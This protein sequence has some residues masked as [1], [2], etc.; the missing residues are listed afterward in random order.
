LFAD[1]LHELLG[2]RDGRD[3]GIGHVPGCEYEDD[4]SLTDQLVD[5][6]SPVELVVA[7]K[8]E[9]GVC[10]AHA[11]DATSSLLRD[12]GNRVTHHDLRPT[13]GEEAKVAMDDVSPTVALLLN[14]HDFGTDDSNVRDPLLG[15]Q[16][17]PHIPVDEN[18]CRVSSMP[19]TIDVGTIS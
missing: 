12:L 17:P 15:V 16:A 9:I 8:D 11:E 6:A 4:P 10:N 3:E 13:V 1:D 19:V 7:I 2:V 5:Q 14:S 18:A